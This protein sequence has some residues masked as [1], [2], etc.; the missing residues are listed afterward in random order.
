MSVVSLMARLSAISASST[1]SVVSLITSLLSTLS[2]AASAEATRTMVGDMA[3]MM[4]P[5]SSNELR[6]SRY[7]PDSSKEVSRVQAPSPSTAAVFVLSPSTNNSTVVLGIPVPFNVTSP[8]FNPSREAG[9]N[10][11]ATGVGS[12]TGVALGTETTTAFEAS[13]V[14]PS[15]PIVVA[16][17]K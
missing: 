3:E 2:A 9:S 12:G 14:W 6:P 1:T 4:L 17:T 10:A 11:G 7:L 16:V 8:M 13:L 15:V 5:S